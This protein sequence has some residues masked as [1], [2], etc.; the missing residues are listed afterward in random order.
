MILTPHL[1]RLGTLDFA[2][3]REAIAAGEAAVATG[4]REWHLARNGVRYPIHL[5]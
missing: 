1:D 2:R 3:M 5:R 4:L